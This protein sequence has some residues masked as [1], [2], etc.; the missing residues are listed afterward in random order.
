MITTYPNYKIQ[1]QILKRIAKVEQQQKDNKIPDTL[2]AK[3]ADFVKDV[4]KLMANR[5]FT[6]FLTTKMIALVDTPKV[7]KSIRSSAAAL[8]DKKQFDSCNLS[9]QAKDVI[10]GWAREV[11]R[12]DFLEI[13]EG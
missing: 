8:M 11:A 13:A 10:K 6:D 2:P 12:K 5:D 9:T 3:E 1:I 4:K 7:Q